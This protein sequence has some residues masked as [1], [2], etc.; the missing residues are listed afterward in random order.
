MMGKPR[1]AIAELVDKQVVVSE[2]RVEEVL[3]A[4]P[5]LGPLLGYQVKDQDD[6]REWPE[7]LHDLL[8]KCCNMSPKELIAL[9]PSDLEV[10]WNTF[11]KVNPF[12]FVFLRWSGMETAIQEIVSSTLDG[13][14]KEF[15]NFL[16]KGIMESL[17]TAGAGLSGLSNTQTG[18]ETSE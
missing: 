6:Q 8:I 5:F 9:Y 16:R 12:F 1:T 4:L 18:L 17:T 14:G 13:F 2:V 3:E 15:V 10:L 7:K 11:Q